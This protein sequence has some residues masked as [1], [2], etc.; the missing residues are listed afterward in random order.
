MNSRLTCMLILPNSRRGL[1]LRIWPTWLRSM[2]SI[3]H[4]SYRISVRSFCSVRRPR[5]VAVVATV[6]RHIAP[7]RGIEAYDHLHHGRLAGAVGARKRE[8]TPGPAEKLSRSPASLSQQRLVRPLASVIGDLRSSATETHWYG[9]PSVGWIG[10]YHTYRFTRSPGAPLPSAG[11]R[12]RA[13]RQWPQ[14]RAF[15]PG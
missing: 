15:R 4:K 12:Q 7:T 9:Y 5:E 1:P 2:T 10:L 6:H 14:T 3:M 13:N 8:T 11:D